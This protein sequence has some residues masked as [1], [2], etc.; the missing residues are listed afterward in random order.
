VPAPASLGVLAPLSTGVVPPSGDVVPPSLGGGGGGG[1]TG[2]HTPWMDPGDMTQGRP[3][4]QS[5]LA[6]HDWPIAWQVFGLHASWPP[7]LGTHGWPQHSLA[8]EQ[9]PFAV[10]QATPP[11]GVALSPRHRGIPSESSSQTIAFGLNV[12][13]QSDAA[14]EI[15]HA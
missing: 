12:P 15:E 14:A 5:A 8:L 10:T 4:Q 7:E 13:Q 9:A 6:V 11:S 1:L 2:V 3:G